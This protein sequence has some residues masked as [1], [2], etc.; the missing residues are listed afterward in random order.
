MSYLIETMLARSMVR[1]TIRLGLLVTLVVLALSAC[2]GGGSSAQEVANKPR[3]LPEN[4]VTLRSGEYRSV[5]FE[6]SFSFKVGEGWIHEAPELPDKLAIS[7]GR[8]GGD[9]LLIFRNLRE[10][11]KPTKSAGTPNVVEA[12]EDMVAWFQ[13]HPYL[14]TDKPKP[15][16]IGGVKGQKFEWVVAEDVPYADVDTFKYSD[17]SNAAVAKG[18]KHRAIVLE[19]VKGETVTIG[20]GSKA[21]EFDEFAPEAQ[22]VLESVKWGG[23]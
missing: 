6:P 21:S 20:I 7:P 5:E 13:N 3:P 12:P 4:N 14:I 17:G 8:Q 1:Q 19:D 16:T 18:F 2:S 11:Y 9:P 10:V 22:K 23:S 15:V